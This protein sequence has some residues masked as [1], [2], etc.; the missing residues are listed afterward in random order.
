LNKNVLAT[1]SLALLLLV[2]LLPALTAQAYEVIG[3]GTYT[4]Y[5]DPG[6][7]KTYGIQL[8]KDAHVTVELHGSSGTEF[9]LYV[10]CAELDEGEPGHSEHQWTSLNPGSHESVE[11]TVPHSGL[12]YIKVPAGVGS[13][14]GEVVG[15]DYTLVVTVSGGGPTGGLDWSLILTIV[16]VV[17]VV[18][19]AVIF[20]MMRGRGAPTVARPPTIPPSKITRPGCPFCG[21]PLAP[22]QTYCPNCKKDITPINLPAPIT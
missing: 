10:N 6:D 2:M 16:G 19:V 13:G 4:G 7:L 21:T 12:Y 9:D 5:L 11:F 15:G 18:A 17:A 20:L 8:N 14:A 3:P 1:A 22:G